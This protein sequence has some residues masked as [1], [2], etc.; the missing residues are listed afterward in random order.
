MSATARGI[1]RQRHDAAERP[2]IVIWESTRACPLTCRHCRAEAVPDRDPRELGT[3]AAKDLLGVRMAE[4][5][6]RLARWVLALTGGG[7]LTAVAGPAAGWRPAVALGSTAQ[8]TKLRQETPDAWV[9]NGIAAQYAKRP[10]KAAAGERVRF[11]VVAAGPS[12]GIAFHL[13]GT[14]FDTLY[15]EGAHLL[16]PDKAGG[17][18]VLDLATAQGGFVETTFPEAGHYAFVDHDTRHADAGAHGMVEVSD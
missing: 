7:L 10:L 4:R 14:V 16:K 9:F 1:R 15:K 2:F 6:T 3:A 8:V 12:D 11:W 13:V 18:Q 17:A 5:T